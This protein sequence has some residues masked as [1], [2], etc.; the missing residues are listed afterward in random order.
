MYI[1]GG[2]LPPTSLQ[3]VECQS[4]KSVYKLSFEDRIKEWG[5]KK[6]EAQGLKDLKNLKHRRYMHATCPV[7]FQDPNCHYLLVS[8]G[9][10]EES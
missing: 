3:E 8:G 1:V 4:L 7:L 6:I 10:H 5:G 9:L 2:G